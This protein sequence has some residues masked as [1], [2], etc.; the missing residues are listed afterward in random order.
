MNSILKRIFKLDWR[1]R[2]SIAEIRRR[3]VDLETVYSTKHTAERAIIEPP[4]PAKATV[5]PCDAGLRE[6]P[7]TPPRDGDGVRSP[8]P[9]HVANLSE[10]A[11]VS[12]TSLLQAFDGI[13]IDERHPAASAIEEAIY[14][15]DDHPAF[16]P[17]RAANAV[18][19]PSGLS[20]VEHVR[21]PPKRLFDNVQGQARPRHPRTSLI[22]KPSLA[23]PSNSDST[24]SGQTS[25]PVTPQTQARD[26]RHGDG[27][28]LLALPPDE[29][30]FRLNSSA[31]PVWRLIPHGLLPGEEEKAKSKAGHQGYLR[32]PKRDWY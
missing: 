17:R 7:P 32:A 19:E 3:V 24:G 1:E 10:T 29:L 8:W 12:A 9:V 5:L 21:T 13:K 18:V 26:A 27:A 25:G 22:S 4:R 23:P 11:W 2:L 14:A 16:Y 6:I 30:D 28:S 15:L 31:S 20:S